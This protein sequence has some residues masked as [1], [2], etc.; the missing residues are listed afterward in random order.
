MSGA[1]TL[2]TLALLAGSWP[3][4]FS[5]VPLKQFSLDQLE[6]RRREIDAELQRLATYNLGSGIGAI[7]Y[8]SQAHDTP[9]HPEWIEIDFGQTRRLDEI[10]LVPTIRRDPLNGFQADAFPQTLRVVAGTDPDRVGKA[11]AAFTSQSGLLP[12]IAPVVIPCAG[13]EAS[14]IRIEA[15][16][17]SP[18]AFDGRFVFQLAEVLAFSGREN[19]ALRQPVRS[20]SGSS[21][22]I[23]PGWAESYATDGILPYLMAAAD[24]KGSVAFVNQSEL[25]DDPAIMI[26]LG[27]VQRVTRVH[28]HTIDQSDTVPQA[29]AG[30][31]GI[32][33]LLR[34]EGART[35]DF[36]DA[37]VLLEIRH[38]TIYDAGPILMWAVPP[39]ECRYVRFR[40]IGNNATSVL[41]G[42]FGERFGFAELEIFSG[43]RNIA[44]HQTVTAN[45]RADAPN[46]L[47]SNLTDGRN[48]FGAILPVRDWLN[49]LATR[50]ELE[51]ERPALRAEID[52][53]HSLQRIQ[54]TALAW[55]TALLGFGVI[56]IAL[57]SRI[58]RQRAIDQTRKRIAADLHDEL[59]ADLHAVG[60]LTDLARGAASHDEKLV[61]LMQRMR[62]L[63]ERAGKAARYC[64]NMLEAPGLFGDLAG[65]MRRASARILADL[66]HTLE[67]EDSELL[68][69]LEPQRRI[70]LLLFYQECLINIIRHSGATRVVARLWIEK[71]RIHLMVSDNGHGL[72]GEIPRSLKRRARLLRAD[73]AATPAAPSGLQIHLRLKPRRFTLF[74]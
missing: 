26:D 21:Q 28:L 40:A 36:A 73:L 13:I 16:K 47:L 59:G 58:Q 41:Y 56:V 71:G 45:F 46:R 29:Y 7:G 3:A 44:L 4:L 22:S 48:F 54:L 49:Q 67:I 12:R 69:K 31:L 72:H 15:E 63:T 14:W 5:A 35:P 61:G 24:A 18:R 2:L 53:R 27:S 65:D 57:V 38:D 1:R 34:I 62:N 20:S 39:A 9:D 33:A 30:D 19:A 68:Q 17:L 32:P 60:L 23:T 51:R 74:P 50:H 64:T 52:R 55:L 11:I 25:G 37:T 8:R 43:E 70:D 66:E 42:R 10:V 6:H